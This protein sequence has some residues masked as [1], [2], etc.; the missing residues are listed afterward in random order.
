MSRTTFANHRGVVP[1]LAALAGL[2]TLELCVVHLFV[3]L[4]WPRVGWP[5]TVA[6]AM[7]IVWLIGWIGSWRRLPHELDGDLLMLR[8]G[9]LRSIRVPL[10]SIARISKDVSRADLKQRGTRNLV[11][12]A[13]PNRLI[14]LREPL[15]GR[16]RTTRIAVRLD[17]PGAFDAA[18]AAAGVTTS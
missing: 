5:L 2:A 14:V 7:S 3:A 1:M 15:P 6:S 18:L 17:D 16:R 4:K 10:A 8:M 11:P 9:S 12:V 13:F